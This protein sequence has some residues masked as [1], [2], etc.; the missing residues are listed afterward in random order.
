FT[1]NEIVSALDIRGT[2]E[3]MAAGLLTERGVSHVLL[4]LLKGCLDDGD[5][6]F[7]KRHLAKGDEFIYAQMNERFHNAIV[8]AADHSIISDLVSRLHRIPVVVPS[9]IAFDEKSADEMFDLLYHAHRQHHA[10]T[11]ALEA[12]EGARAEALLK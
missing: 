12:G 9:S 2:L 4:R 10:I 7:A 8:E 11:G 1:I 6:L 5:A 3:G